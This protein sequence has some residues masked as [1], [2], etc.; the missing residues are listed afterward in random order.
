[1]EYI[2]NA[3]ALGADGWRRPEDLVQAKAG[4]PHAY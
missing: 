1:M 2:G 4:A 3:H